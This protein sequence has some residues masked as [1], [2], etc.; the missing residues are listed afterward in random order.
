MRYTRYSRIVSI[1]SALSV[2]ISTSVL[3]DINCPASESDDVDAIITDHTFVSGDNGTSENNCLASNTIRVGGVPSKWVIILE[4]TQVYL[5]APRGIDLGSDVSVAQGA[6]LHVALSV[7]LNDTGITS[8][9]D[10]SKNDLPCPQPSFPS[11]DAEYGRDATHNDDSDGHAGFN[12]TKQGSECVKDNVTGLIWEVKADD[13]GL[14]DKD[15]QYAWYNTDSATNGGDPG[16]DGS[17][18]CYGYSYSDPASYCNTQAYL[19]RVNQAGWCGYNDWR[20][21]TR[22]ELRSLVDYSVPDPGPTVDTIYYPNDVG[23]AVWSSSPHATYP[24]YAWLLNFNDG[25]DSILPKR[26]SNFVRL[27]RGKQ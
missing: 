23:T 18:T 22:E 8:C 19:A 20:I 17:N 9:S 14:H 24:V 10:L 4:G 13:D 16:D 2:L 5:V 15:D 12:F 3:A 7:K 25:S 6:T 21:P 1:M 27:V 11:Q 26:L